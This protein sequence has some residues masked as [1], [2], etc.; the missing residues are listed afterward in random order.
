MTEK[1]QT[2][3]TVVYYKDDYC[4]DSSDVPNECLVKGDIHFSRSVMLYVAVS[5]LGKPQFCLFSLAVRLIVHITV[6]CIWNVDCC[7]IFIC[8]LMIT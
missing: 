1:E 7:W 6:N 8:Y 2:V 5:A 4:T 3:S